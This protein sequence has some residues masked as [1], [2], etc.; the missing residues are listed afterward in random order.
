[1]VSVAGRRLYTCYERTG[2][3]LLGESLSVGGVNRM[4]NSHQHLV[5]SYLGAAHRSYAGTP[6]VGPDGERDD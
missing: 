2:I 1:M 3:V 4:A 5:R 6:R